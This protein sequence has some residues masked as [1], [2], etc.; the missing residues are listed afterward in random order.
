MI[1]QT[2]MYID[3][4]GKQTSSHLSYHICIYIYHVRDRQTTIENSRKKYFSMLISSTLLFSIALY[5]YNMK[6]IRHIP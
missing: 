6:L 5:L 4:R 1:F 3:F 2:N